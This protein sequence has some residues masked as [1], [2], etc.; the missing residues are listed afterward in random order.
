MDP[1][2]ASVL[3]AFIAT[4]GAIAGTIIN[5]RASS[6]LL[7]KAGK[8]HDLEKEVRRLGGNPDDL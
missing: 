4:A 2:T 7:A 3:V 6:D 1:A 8:I 5:A